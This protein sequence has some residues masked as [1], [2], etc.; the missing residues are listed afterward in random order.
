MMNNLIQEIGTIRQSML[1]LERRHLAVAGGSHPNH[2]ESQRNLLHYLALRTN[3]LRPLQR[4]LA[5]LGCHR[6]DA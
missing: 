3:D 6:S 1:E 4:E 5:V 2:A